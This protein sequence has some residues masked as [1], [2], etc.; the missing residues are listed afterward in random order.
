MLDPLLKTDTL[1]RELEASVDPALFLDPQLE[2][3]RQEMTR[4]SWFHKSTLSPTAVVVATAN[5]GAESFSSDNEDYNDMNQTPTLGPSSSSSSSGSTAVVQVGYSK[6]EIITS[7]DPPLNSDSTPRVESPVYST[8]V[9]MTGRGL[10]GAGKTVDTKQVE[11]DKNEE[12]GAEDGKGD[13]VNRE[14]RGGGM[15]VS[16]SLTKKP[17]PPAPPPKK[18][19]HAATCLALLPSDERESGGEVGGNEE[20]GRGERYAN[21]AILRGLTDRRDRSLSIPSP[22]KKPMPLPRKAETLNRADENGRGLGRS[23]PDNF[24]PTPPPRKPTLVSSSPSGSPQTSRSQQPPSQRRPPVLPKPSLTL[25]RTK[26]RPSLPRS[27]TP[28]SG[29]TRPSPPTPQK[30]IAS[31]SRQTGEE[32]PAEEASSPGGRL[33]NDPPKVSPVAPPRRKRKSQTTPTHQK[34]PIVSPAHSSPEK[35]IGPTS[36]GTGSTSDLLETSSESD[37]SHSRSKFPPSP[38][39]VPPSPFARPVTVSN[40]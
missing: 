29:R 5:D 33:A 10:R 22:L 15:K 34:T 21:F 11:E 16:P 35:T 39:P 17:L 27:R 19:P 30:P 14:K 23:L 25:P 18:V 4:R 40:L 1:R 9:K 24:K 38:S 7:E 28:P 31:S 12:E 26:P 2:R 3:Q 13:C 6:V 8:P 32:H 36:S 37:L 20:G